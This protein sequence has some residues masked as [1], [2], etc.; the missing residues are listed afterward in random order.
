MGLLV[1]DLLDLARLDEGR[2]LDAEPLDLADLAAD[3]VADARAV[4]PA[5]PITLDVEGPV[6]TVGDEALIRQV[7]AN[8]LANVR[9]HTSADAAVTVRARRA[10]GAAVV[11]VADRGPGMAPDV[12][13]H[14]F[15]RFFRADPGRTRPTGGSGLGLS[16]VASIVTA[17]HGTAEVVPT[18]GGGTTVRVSLPAT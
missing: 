9:V 4:E 18:P 1:R 16:I 10:P 2:P 6:P 8:L 17:H 14:A 11:E 7:L 15:E 13:A 3:A 12:A 5:R